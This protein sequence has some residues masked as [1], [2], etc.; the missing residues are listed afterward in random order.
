[1]D[2]PAGRTAIDMRRTFTLLCVC[3]L[4]AAHAAAETG[5][6]ARGNAYAK[7]AC[8]QCH[9]IVPDGSASPNARAPTFNRI[10]DTPGM[11]ATALTVF[12]RTPHPTMPNIVVGR[13]DLADIIAFILSQRTSR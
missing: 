1:V 8:A 6:V 12:L 3:V 5:D 10:A 2:H 9:A 7:Q 4:T 11:T 13:E